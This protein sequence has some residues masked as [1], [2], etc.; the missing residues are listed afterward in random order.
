MVVVPSA[1]AAAMARIGYSSIIEGARSGGTATAVRALER[2]RRSATGSPASIRR[3][4]K[5]MSAPIS[6]RVS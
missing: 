4:R 5:V 3:F 6:I 1:Q 2:T